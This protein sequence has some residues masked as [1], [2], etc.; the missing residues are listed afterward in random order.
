MSE[1]TYEEVS[2]SVRVT[3]APF[4]LEDESAPEDSQYVWAY[5]II[6]ENMREDTV[7]LVR[8]HWRIADAQGRVQEVDGD[9]V[10]GKQPVLKPGEIFEYVSGAPLET[11]SGM[12]LG[13]YDMQTETGEIINVAI[14]AFSL[15]SPYEQSKAN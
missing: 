4:Y 15:D 7:Q 3:A 5:K 12:M 11:P 1:D 13:S 2:N 14:P 8:R 9:G 10:V 6:I